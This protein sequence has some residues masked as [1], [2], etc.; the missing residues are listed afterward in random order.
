MHHELARLIAKWQAPGP[1]RSATLARWE[2][3]SE[4]TAVLAFIDATAIR[5]AS[6]RPIAPPQPEPPPRPAGPWDENG[7]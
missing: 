4:L 5:D 7:R 1:P 3:A 2:C 6:G